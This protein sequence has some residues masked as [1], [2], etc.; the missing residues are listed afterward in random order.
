MAAFASLSVASAAIRV[1]SLNLCSDEYALL[2]AHPGELVS[3]TR[4]SH[5]PAESV[6]EPDAR[7]IAS[8]RGRLEDVLRTRP[9]VVL[10][11][12][13]GG[14]SSGAIARTM[15]IKVVDLPQP[16]RLDAVA[17][18]L[19]RVASALGDTRRAAPWLARLATLRRSVPT[20]AVD[21]IWLG[22]GGL[23]LSPGGLSAQWLALAGLRQRALPAAR[24]NL[25]TLVRS[26]PRILIQ[27]DYRSGQMSQ[28]QRWLDHPLLA[29]LPS[30]R[31]A[32]DGRRWTCAGPLLI[33]EIERLR[34]IVR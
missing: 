9:T 6:L 8:N 30:R 3:V 10:T 25:E 15:G 18:N 23:T 22:G 1:A 19:V 5:D 13:G 24:A 33:D 12:G 11:M 7:G 31:M 20:S 34:R 2:L 28:G 32:T 26:P 16:T 27:S 4:L 14:R 17:G 21:T 29:R